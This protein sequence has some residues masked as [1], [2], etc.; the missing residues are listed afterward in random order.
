MSVSYFSRHNKLLGS[1]IPDSINDAFDPANHH[2]VH[3]IVPSG[4]KRYT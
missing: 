2:V 4:V 1:V 3:N